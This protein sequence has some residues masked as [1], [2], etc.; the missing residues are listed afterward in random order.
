M[1]GPGGFRGKAAIPM[2]RDIKGDR[3]KLSWRL[4]SLYDTD[5]LAWS[6][7]QAEAL[8]AALRNGSDQHLDFGK[9]GGGDRRFG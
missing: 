9:P 7:Q 2:F 1:M 5:F 4:K 6:K 3:R 8:R